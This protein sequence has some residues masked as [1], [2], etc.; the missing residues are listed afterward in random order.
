MSTRA[1]F[2]LDDNDNPLGTAGFI[3]KSKDVY[4]LYTEGHEGAFDNKRM[5]VKFGRMMLDIA[6]KNGWTLVASAD[7]DLKTSLSFATHFGFEVDGKGGYVK[8][9][10]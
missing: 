5:V 9:A 10:R 6:K 2:L 3:R 1:Y 7:E 8:W 4:F